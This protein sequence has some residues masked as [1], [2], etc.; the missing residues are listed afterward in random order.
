MTVPCSQN[1][2]Q[3]TAMGAGELLTCKYS[4]TKSIAGVKPESGQKYQ[5][6]DERHKIRLS[7]RNNQKTQHQPQKT[8]ADI[9]HENFRWRPV[10]CQKGKR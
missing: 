10:E 1:L 9:A 2:I 6:G 8:A 5:R 3:V 7:Q 4:H